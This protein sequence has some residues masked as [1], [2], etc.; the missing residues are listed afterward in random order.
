MESSC[1]KITKHEEEGLLEV[2]QVCLGVPLELKDS[3]EDII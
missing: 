1:F 3:T 2:Y